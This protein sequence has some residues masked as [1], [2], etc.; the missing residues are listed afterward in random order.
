M[1]EIKPGT[2][3]ICKNFYHGI[4]FVKVDRETKTTYILDGYQLKLRKPFIEGCSAMGSRGY[5]TDSYYT[6]T[7]ELISQYDKQEAVKKIREVE[8][9][10]LPLDILTE[11]LKLIK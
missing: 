8:W 5:H 6:P 11:I 3:L 4:S 7:P 2:E 1:E 10:T 9:K